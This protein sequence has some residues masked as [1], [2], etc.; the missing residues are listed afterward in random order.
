MPGFD[1]TGPR[2]MGPMTGG[3]RGFCNPRGIGTG[4]G[5]G[6]GMGYGRG[7][8]MGYGRGRGW[9]MPYGAPQAWAASYPARMTREDEVEYL[10]SDAD[11]LRQELEQVENR[12]KELESEK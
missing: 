3:G 5:R 12:L 6:Y 4:S 7:R 2:G 11:A 1:G 9:G 8:G 10:K